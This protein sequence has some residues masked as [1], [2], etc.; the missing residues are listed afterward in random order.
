[1]K[2]R[3]ATR[4]M[5]IFWSAMMAAYLIAGLIQRFLMNYSLVIWLNLIFLLLCF[6]MASKAEGGIR[7]L[8]L[9][10]E[11][12][13]PSCKVGLV[14]SVIILLI[15]GVIPGIL[16]GSELASAAS[17]IFRLIY[18]MV[19]ISIPEEIIFRGY[20]LNTLEQRGKSRYS[21]VIISGVLFM[22]L[23]IPYQMAVSGN[24]ID[25]LL[26]GYGATLVMTFVWHLVFCVLLKKTGAI[27]GAVLFHG[28]MDWSNYLF[29][30]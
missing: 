24:F 21:P 18:F 5:T 19:F 13:L 29:I 27:Y 9:V 16:S 2:N 4:Q 3:N 10:R 23:H 7:S 28:V 30:S 22:L 1:M 26:N 15:N 6:G 8:G 12:F 11:R 17:I 20:I 14:C 25:L